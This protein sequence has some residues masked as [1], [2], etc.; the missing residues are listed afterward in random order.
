MG[1]T[2][3]RLFAALTTITIAAGVPVSGQIPACRPADTATTASSLLAELTVA[4]P[5]SIPYDRALF[6]HSVDADADGCDTRAEVLIATSLV[7][8]TTPGQ[9]ARSPQGS[10]SPG[11][12]V[13]RGRTRPMWT[14]TIWFHSK[15]HGSPVHGRGLLT[16]ARRLPMILPRPAPCKQ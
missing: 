11:T 4:P 1:D 12:T 5:S 13:P 16:S 3:R 10:G 2:K 6:N 15:R 8:V 9:V 7:P 14:L